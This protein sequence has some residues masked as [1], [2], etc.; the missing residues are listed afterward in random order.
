MLAA[1]DKGGILEGDIIKANRAHRVG[2]GRC[3]AFVVVRGE[4]AIVAIVTTAGIG[5]HDGSLALKF[6]SGLLLSGMGAEYAG[7][8]VLHERRRQPVGLSRIV[9]GTHWNDINWG[10]EGASSKSRL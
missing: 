3:K 8:E 10:L 4:Q 5:L 2:D 6:C 7:E 1:F 9:A